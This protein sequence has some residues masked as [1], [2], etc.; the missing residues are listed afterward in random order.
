MTFDDEISN[1]GGELLLDESKSDIQGNYLTRDLYNTYVKNIDMF[2]NPI[3]MSN[4]GGFGNSILL[5]TSYI[6]SNKIISL[7]GSDRGIFSRRFTTSL[8]T[9]YSDRFR[10]TINR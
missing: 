8:S 2:G 10:I 7:I 9:G 3:E 1:E 6:S 4:I 5:N